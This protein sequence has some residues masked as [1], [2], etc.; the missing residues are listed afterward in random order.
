MRSFKLLI[1]W[2]LALSS[3]LAAC[4]SAD[5]TPEP[6]PVQW[7]RVTF[8]ASRLHPGFALNIPGYWHY[9]VTE[10][11]IIAF[12]YPRLLELQDDGAEMPSGAIVVSISILSAVDMQM[13]GVRNAAGILDSFV[14]V[15]AAEPAEPQYSDANV[16]DIAGRDGAQSVVSIN[17]SDSLLLALELSGNYL[18]SIIVTPG[19]ELDVHAELLNL[20]FESVELR[21]DA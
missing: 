13:M 7:Q 16:I 2:L 8:V 18:L 4:K 12:N 3:I 11:G 19:G 17:N 15:T 1:I 6:T 14:G 10:T 21:L 9:E 5:V 20:I